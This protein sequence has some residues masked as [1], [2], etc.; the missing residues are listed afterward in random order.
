MKILRFQWDNVPTICSTFKNRFQVILRFLELKGVRDPF[1]IEFN[2]DLKIRVRTGDDL[3]C[4]WDC[5]ISEDYRI[6]GNEKII[7]DVGANIGSF[8]LYAYY[9]CPSSRIFAFEPVGSTYSDLVSNIELNGL[10]KSIKTVKVGVAGKTGER[11]IDISDASPYSSLF[12]PHKD[13]PNEVISVKSL[14]AIVELIGNPKCV[15]ILKMDCEGAEME[16]L[17]SANHE[18]I[19]RFKKIL[20]EYHEFSGIKFETLKAHLTSAGFRCSKIHDDPEYGVGI[21]WFEQIEGP[22]LP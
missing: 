6:S 13:G 11:R 2:S 4:V 14:D 16:C 15:D 19:H 5:W 3:T 9:K 7:V 12:S 21:A 22:V 8:S 18:T 20:L 17:L 1:I 10:E